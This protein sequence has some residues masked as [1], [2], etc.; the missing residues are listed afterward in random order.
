MGYYDTTNLKPFD[1]EVLEI[2]F[3]NQLETRLNLQQF[4]TV[5]YSLAE[6]PG[7]VKKIRTYHGTGVLEELAMGEGNTED[8]GAYWDEVEYRVGTTQ[9]RAPYYDE[10]SMTDPYVIDKMINHM[11]EEMTND[12][13]D[14]I[15]AEMVK[16]DNKIYD[17]DFDFD[18]ISDAIASFP[19]EETED[20]TLFMLVNRKDMTTFR[21]NLKDQ[22]KYVEDFVRKG[23]V[24][25]V[26]GVPIYTSDAVPQGKIFLGTSKAVTIFVKKGVETER[27]RDA[28]TRK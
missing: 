16:T 10:Q 11:S 6:Q 26:C 9:G 20:E 19:D 27:E 14:K 2:K 3:E 15:V 28:N 24:G 1:S 13:T 4:A 17:A 22:L 23:Y 5:D 18:V 25:T 21:K 8:F 12:L 7:M